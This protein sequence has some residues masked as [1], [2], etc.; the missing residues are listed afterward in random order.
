MSAPLP[1]FLPGPGASLFPAAQS[2]LSPECVFFK[3]RDRVADESELWI[4]HPK[5]TEWVVVPGP[6]TAL[7]AYTFLDVDTWGVATHHPG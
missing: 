1:P 3:V 2:R 4:G 6:L 7:L 5:S